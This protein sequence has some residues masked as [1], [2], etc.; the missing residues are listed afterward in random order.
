MKLDK[1]IIV[2]VFT[3]VHGL[4]YYIVDSFMQ[5]EITMQPGIILYNGGGVDADLH[6]TKRT[7]LFSS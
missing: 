7:L 5:I 6:V 3:K 4:N 2:I 1:E